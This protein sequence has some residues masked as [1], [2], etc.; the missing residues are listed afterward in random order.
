MPIYQRN[1]KTYNIPDSEVEGFE[2]T[3]PDA[4][5][6]YVANGRNYN[7]P[8]SERNGFI[9]TYKDAT[10]FDK[11]PSTTPEVKSV[12]SVSVVSQGVDSVKDYKPV[13]QEKPDTDFNLKEVMD[14]PTDSERKE[15]ERKRIEEQIAQQKLDTGKGLKKAYQDHNRKEKEE[16]EQKGWFRRIVEGIS[17]SG[18]D[19]RR[20]FPLS[21]VQ[22]DENIRNLHAAAESVDNAEELFNESKHKEETGIGAG[23]AGFGR[24]FWD[25]MSK[26]STWDMGM[27]DMSKSTAVLNAAHKFDLNQPLTGEE[28]TLL[29]AVA[30][31]A[32]ANGEFS[33][34]LGRGYK[35][36]STTAESLPFMAEFMVNPATGTGQAVGKAAAKKIIFN[37]GKEAAKSTI[38]KIARNSARVAGDIVG[39]GIMTGTTGVMRTTADAV[40]RSI[41]EVK[42]IVDSDGYYRFGGT[43]G[44][45]GALEAFVKAYG[46]S[47]IENFS[48]MFGNYLAPIGGAL[49]TG[50]GKVMNKIGLG[51]VNK[52]IGDIKSSDVAK[53][54]DDFQSK[55]QWNGTIGEYLEEQAGMA[56]NA[57]TVGD[58]NLSDIVD[59]DTQI[60]TFLGVSA[61]G[62]LFSTIRTAGYAKQKYL[63]KNKLTESDR[64]A[65][66]ALGEGW[67][68]L[69]EQIDNSDDE[70]LISIL[71]STM[72]GQELDE[73]QKQNVLLYAGRLKAYHGASLADLKRKTEGDTPDEIVQSQMNFD[74]GYKLAVADRVEKRK[75]FKELK[76]V[77]DKIDEEF[78]SADEEGQYDI[79]RHRSEAGEDVTNELAYIDASSKF[80][81]MICGIRDGINEKV[82]QS[83]QYITRL[84]HSDGN[85]YDVTLST[86]EKKHVF[87]INGS[88]VADENGIIDKKQS[89]TRFIVRDDTGKAVMR[90][91]DDL[92]KLE[93]S[94]NAESLK[95]VTAK[96]IR[97]QESA[98]YAEEIETP[99]ED[100]TAKAVALIQPGDIAS[101]NMQGIAATAIVQSKRD[102]TTVL[103]LDDPVEYDGKKVQA[104]EL[105]DEQ[106]QAMIISKQ[107]KDDNMLENALINDATQPIDESTLSDI[108][109]PG[110]DKLKQEEVNLETIGNEMPI[111]DVPVA[112]SVIPTDDKGNMLYHKA[113]VELTIADL[114]DGNLTSDEADGL[115]AAN[116]KE[117]TKQL[118]KTSEKPPK[119][120][121]NK[122]KYLEEKRKWTDAVADINSQIAYWNEVEVQLQA[123]REQPGDTTAND[124]KAMGEPLSGNELAAQLLG[125]GKLPLLYGDY[126]RETGFNYSEAKGMFGLFA[127]KE[128]GGMTIEQA[129]EQLMLADLEA[130]T[131]FFDQDD[132]NAGRNAIVDILSSVRTRGGL[133]NYIE[134]NR[135]DMAERERRAEV[136]ANELA[137]EQWYQDNY[138]MTPEEYE[139]YEEA[140]ADD[141]AKRSLS[142]KE[143]NEFMSTFVDEQNLNS[144]EQQ[145]VTRE[146][147]NSREILS[148]EEPVQTGR[149]GGIEEESTEVDGSVIGEN[150]VIP[151]S[152][153]GGVEILSQDSK[154]GV[155]SLSLDDFLKSRPEVP[156]YLYHGSPDGDLNMIDPFAHTQNWREGIG[157]YTTE[158]RDAAQMYADGR[159]AKGERKA[160]AGKVNYIKPNPDARIL[161]MDAE[162][163][164]KLWEGISTNMDLYPPMDAKTNREAYREL[165]EMADNP[166]AQYA[167]EEA[168]LANG[169]DAS[170]HMEGANGNPHRVTIW[171]NPDKLPLITRPEDVYSESLPKID[172]ESPD[173]NKAVNMLRQIEGESILDYAERVVKAN[174][175]TQER[176]KVNANPT[177]A[178]KEAGNYKKGHVEINGLDM[179]IENPRGSERSGVD[180]NG[181]TWSITM[182]NDYGYIRGTVGVDGDHIDVF[183]SDDPMQGDV[184]V[185]DQV[186]EDGSFDEHKVMYGFG[187]MDEAKEAYLSNYSPGW[188]GLGDITGVSKDTFK[189]WIESS[190]RKTKPFAEYKI[191]QESD[192]ASAMT[193]G[194]YHPKDNNP[195]LYTHSGE[196]SLGKG[197]FCHVERVFTESASFQFTGKEKIESAD[198]VAYIFRE[199]ENS[200]IENSFAVLVKDQKPT[201]VH[202][203]MGAFTST[204]ANIAAIKAAYNAVDADNIYFVHNHPSGNLKCSRQDVGLLD[205]IIKMFEHEDVIV[206]DGIIINTVSGEYGTFDLEGITETAKR[207]DNQEEFPLRLYSFDKLVFSKD[208]DPSNLSKI[209]SSEDVAAFVSSHRLGKRKKVS[210]LILDNANHVLGNLHTTFSSVKENENSLADEI[211][212]NV[213]RFGGTSAVVYGSFDMKE[214]SPESLNR[215]IKKR[216]SGSVQLLDCISINGKNT[217]GAAD[218]GL[219]E[220]ESVYESSESKMDN[221]KI[222]DDENR[223]LTDKENLFDSAE[224]IVEQARIGKNLEQ[225]ILMFNN[226]YNS[227][228]TVIL[229]GSMADEQLKELGIGNEHIGIVR[230]IL[231]DGKTLAGFVPSL[232]KILIFADNISDSNLSKIESTLFHENIHGALNDIYGEESR[233]IAQA[234]YD[235]A[236]DNYKKL[237]SFLKANY[238]INEVPE[239]FF[240]YM[241]EN[242]MSEGNF[243]R[244]SKFLKNE[245]QETL[246]LIFKNIGYDKQR[247]EGRGTDNSTD[248]G[249]REMWNGSSSGINEKKEYDGSRS[250]ISRRRTGDNGR[251]KIAFNEKM[252]YPEG[253]IGYEEESGRVWNDLRSILNEGEERLR[254]K[255]EEESTGSG[256]NELSLPEREG[257]ARQMYEDSLDK[258]KN[259]M[260]RWREAYQDSML[261]LKNLQ[262]AIVKESREVLKHFED[263]YMAENQMSSR[264]SFET[265]V[266][267]DKFFV[268]MMDAIKKIT[269]QGVDR[270]EVNI[271]VMAKHGLERN[272]VFA[273]R[274][275]EQA[276]NNEFDEKISEVNKLL[277]EGSITHEEWE[278]KTDE[279]K[280][281]KADLYEQEYVKNRQKDYSGLTQLTDEKEG[282]E[283]AAKDIVESFEDR[284]D[285]K[286]LWG[287]INLAT[288]QTLKKSYE[289][290]LMTKATYKKINSMFEHYVP[291]R[292]FEDEVASD[293]YDYMLSDKSPFNAP[294]QAA[295]GRESQ[296][297]DPFAT[298]G[299]MA[300]SSILQGNRNLMKQKFLNMVMNHPTSLV[301]VKT[302]W[303]ERVVTG[304]KEEWVESF[305]EIKEG[306]TPD[307]VSET[308]EEHERRMLDLEKDRLS[309]RTTS[310]INLDYRASKREKNEH[311]VVVK[312]GG[313][314]YVIYINGNPRAAQA[315]NGLT[316]PD[317]SDN[318]FMKG[319][320]WLDRQMAANFTT[321]NPAFVLSN[322]SRDVIF[323]TSAI[324]VKEDWKYA[325][326]FD[327]NIAK[328]IGAIA[329]LM[330]RYKSGRLNMSVSR[331]RHFLEF[332]ENGGETGY[333][334]LH[335]VD[336]YKKMMDRHVKKSNG[337]LGSVSSG[338][339]A[340]VDAVSFMNRCAENVSRFTTYQT[341]REMGRGISESIRD[342]KEVTVNFNKKGAGMKS[343]GWAGW[344]AQT[345]KSFFLFFNAAVQSLK[346]FKDLHDKSK[347]KF[348]TSIG[349]FASA[350][351]LLPMINNAIIEMLVGDEDDDM[352][353]EERAE[354][355]RKRSAYD[356]LPEWVRKNNFCIWVG[357]ERFVTIPL[358]IELRAFYGLG[359]MW[360]QMGRG[361]MNGIDGKIDVKKAS[362]EMVNQLT[363]LLP[364]NPLGGNGDALSVIVPDAGK[365]LYQVFRNKDFF[366][367]PIYKKGDYNELMPAWTKAFSGTAKWM[368]NSAEFINEVSGGDKYMQGEVDLN[369]AT[370]EHVFEG[371]FGGMGK[372]ANQL[373]KTISMIWDEDERMWRNVPVA[374]RFVSGSDN[375]IEFRKVNEVYYQCMD[376]LKETEQRLRGYENEAEM[377]IE[378]YAEKYDFLNESK[379]NERYQV[380]KEY[381]SF[382]DELQKAVKESD[383]EE[384]KDIEMK[385]NLLK[386]EMIGEV[387]KIR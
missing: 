96:A 359:E 350:G 58:N 186:K 113:P 254:R 183:L 26:L 150:G 193:E 40:D 22:T 352:T 188:T 237:D 163:D 57:L 90:S 275:A 119:I 147:K 305:P 21:P 187:S 326:R 29:D 14:G 241:L 323:S 291:L 158:S 110:E 198:D 217:M 294:V 48:E 308:I 19:A 259:K 328:N 148:G 168:L 174:E 206:Q 321:R 125:T 153:S 140:I 132:P 122:A 375:K 208:Y 246:N 282:Y 356:N 49:G 370:I 72:S 123:I 221:E 235:S 126:K 263:A 287:K 260:Y 363:E 250:D 24:G 36:G 340:I 54:I 179:T 61:F 289:S 227:K 175:I 114:N 257:I 176:E 156:G 144:N 345:F 347:S 203:G 37:F 378:Q 204:F 381:K 70:E 42:P 314:E 109:I 95:E 309:I 97:E 5:Q 273:K 319:I 248:S 348:Y 189:K 195:I 365:P 16:D 349:G 155:P 27:L 85:I 286:E 76:K 271:Y 276:A 222:T 243:E 307:E 225:E 101:L 104:I 62:G 362:L 337:A 266:Y 51:R 376:E 245:E 151:E 354:W 131:N 10:P 71:S 181:E 142:E 177:D 117:A 1:G 240:V 346:N 98:R 136:E 173:S 238:D 7:I 317:S 223:R 107:E 281:Q 256:V 293:V 63:A 164:S 220:P 316:N 170:T 265:E 327:K 127:T 11:A 210:Y 139:T 343:E 93:A 368:V 87:V 80:N 272:E 267:K 143:Y 373:Y 302:M 270:K 369:P 82:A 339:H 15:Q 35:A 6:K 215:Q 303:Y 318:K 290:G 12:P 121:I 344:S 197:E 172:E 77:E 306:A 102:G 277:D 134:S 295:K 242:D 115:I 162:I 336:E 116:K 135:E 100:E 382:I 312:S 56:M 67:K 202:L 278:E 379:E 3:Y 233:Y 45:D 84:S 165:I 247:T 120:G 108:S 284:F 4:T 137:K 213:I 138:H 371:Y 386:M 178:Q 301:T 28:D 285:T 81:G 255:I 167:I 190:H 92:Y 332:L 249:K 141:S 320:Q 86:D 2:K 94:N 209:K 324:W 252:R 361:N 118:K 129:G 374:N 333:A 228:P 296:A 39:A 224:R 154:G 41:G 212:Q 292:G 50:A 184:F 157:F 166:E 88:I 43:E 146:G 46:A 372:T 322:M 300:E 128:N 377:G 231:N 25:K 216:S 325:K 297:D 65:S 185:V 280:A 219:M 130:G 338:V 59:V 205:S 269:D 171:K 99:S 13:I 380:M 159:T 342:A 55:T 145:R 364:I 152:A 330:A 311:I 244:Y 355:A 341:S 262:E 124:I 47:T 20:G 226:A 313:K 353:D 229:R 251:S 360:Y 23:V 9:S 133:T 304:D 182:N 200:S 91:V 106:L 194:E 214:F 75:A 268:P 52:V 274:D 38:G 64:E 111:Q 385:I 384:K 253:N 366:G 18:R 207:P 367:K 199:L 33:G 112:T 53:M 299:N 335:N 105:P 283:E 160:S 31:E 331:D 83:N 358:P 211:A 279:L 329:G 310:K 234:F 60:D 34:D 68:P 288:K 298:I 169:Y 66:D 230:D 17:E 201:I 383:A 196:L 69:K 236:K 73:R 89:D 239:E 78:L 180:A 32:A 192:S 79:I 74:E 103:Q 264:S 44:G 387:Q 218:N 258:T 334:A 191:A 30:L 261:A 357:G 232:N 315:I 351:I 149:A 161:D 8:V